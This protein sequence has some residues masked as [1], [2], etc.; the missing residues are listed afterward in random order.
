MKAFPYLALACSF[1]IIACGGAEGDRTNLTVQGKVILFTP[2]MLANNI[3]LSPPGCPPIIETYG[4]SEST[5]VVIK[6]GDGTAISKVNLGAS[7]K[8]HV[9]EPPKPDAATGGYRFACVWPFMTEVPA[10]DVYQIVVEADQNHESTVSA[11]DV[12]Q[13]VEILITPN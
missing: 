1:L 5:A 6:S 3:E 7:T 10:Q 12:A 4:L 2:E 11:A 8:E 9:T 13:P